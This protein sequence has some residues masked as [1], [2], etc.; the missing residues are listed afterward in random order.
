MDSQQRRVQQ[1]I[2]LLA[3]SKHTAA[4]TGAGLSTPSGIPDFRSPDSGIWNRVDPFEVASIFAFRYRPQ[5]FYDWI[6]PLAELIL[7]AGPN[8]AHL[9]LAALE[10]HGPVRS[11]ITQNIDLLH[12]RAGSR[13]VL[14]VH[15]HVRETTC[16]RCYQVSAAADYMLELVASGDLPR[17]PACGGLLKPNVILFG[18]QLPVQVLNQAR[19]EARRCDVML[20]AGTSLEVAPAGD[21]PLLARETGAQLIIVNQSATRLD[22]LADVVIHADVVDILPQ[23]AAH[24]QP[25]R[26]GTGPGGKVAEKESG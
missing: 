18:E 7:A 9:A 12:S 1:A 3:R 23:L 4:L 24:F 25:L 17:C 13:M 16:I 10:A 20:V 15:G 26:S 2:D 11:V 5:A 8:V 19:R 22:G 14:E 21:L 6:R